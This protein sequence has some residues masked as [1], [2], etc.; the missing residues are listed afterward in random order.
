MIVRDF[1]VESS[2]SLV[3]SPPHFQ[4]SREARTAC[5]HDLHTA[6]EMVTR[7]FKRLSLLFYNCLL[8]LYALKEFES[9]LKVI[10]V[11]MEQMAFI[12]RFLN[13]FALN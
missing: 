13:C 10:L 8:K 5:R 11:Q 2:G 9:R 6:N 3:T 4:G 1:F 7:P 12:V